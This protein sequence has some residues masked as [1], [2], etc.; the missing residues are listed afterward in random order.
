MTRGV[1]RGSLIEVSVAHCLPGAITVDV[2]R[3]TDFSRFLIAG[4]D[5]AS[6]AGVLRLAGDDTSVDLRGADHWRSL[7][8]LALDLNKPATERAWRTI[9]A[10]LQTDGR[11]NAI[12]RLLGPDALIDATG[13]ARGRSPLLLPPITLR[14]SWNSHNFVARRH[15]VGLYL[16]SL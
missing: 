6:R 5:A 11:S 3:G 10:A 2:P 15:S 9:A 13:L 7:R 4:A 8:E 1:A 14:R 16:N 12:A